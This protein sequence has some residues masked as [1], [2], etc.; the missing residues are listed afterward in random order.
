MKGEWRRSAWVVVLAAISLVP[1]RAATS[2]PA[3]AAD[4]YKRT[5]KTV[6]PGMKLT[7]IFDRQGPNQIR[8]LTV[9]LT[10]QLT[11]DVALA[12]DT[13]P[14]HE[15][16]SSMAARHDAVA[17]INGDYTIRPFETGAGRPINV[18]AEDGDL[19]ASPL[20]WGRNVG[21][22]VE[23]DVFIG[24]PDFHVKLAQRDGKRA[25]TIDGWNGWRPRRGQ[26][27][28]YSGA[29]GGSF[30]PPHDACSARLLPTPRSFWTGDRTG[31]QRAYTVDAARCGW[32][33]LARRGGVVVSAPRGSRAGTR[34]RRQLDDN[35]VVTLTWRTGWPGVIETIGGNPNLVE[36]GR[37]AVGSCTDPYFCGRNP[38]TGVGVTGSGELLLVTVDGRRSTSVGMTLW[39]FADLFMHLGATWAINLDGGGSS[40]MVVDGR[41]VNRPSDGSE[42]PVGSA[43]L[44]LS[45]PDRNEQQPGPAP[46]PSDDPLPIP[47]PTLTPPDPVAPVDGTST[48]ASATA[49]A[50]AWARAAGCRALGDPASTGGLLNALARGALDGP[51]V[52]GDWPWRQA[53]AVFRGTRA[54]R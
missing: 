46:S 12:N 41:I 20:I 29:G 21:V 10:S 25:W 32:K 24:H 15:R 5:T 27:A 22:S 18:F 50:T 16:P 40:V 49:E 48:L 28:A 54:C 52:E 43:L 4:R 1:L 53:V 14:G 47:L 7:R 38:R 6:T 45:G 13:I 30:S 17:A 23:R 31:V 36:N 39:E 34:L 37:V 35:E 19:V 42:R 44:V 2:E 33:P 51:R 8:V 26:L 3:A 11:I 9:D